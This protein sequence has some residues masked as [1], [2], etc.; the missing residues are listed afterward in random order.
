MET[1]TFAEGAEKIGLRGD[2]LD[3][4]IDAVAAD[5][6]RGDELKVDG[7]RCRRVPPSESGMEADIDVVF[8]LAAP[9]VPIFL[10]DVY[11]SGEEVMLS[12]QERLEMSKALSS[13]ADA[14]RTNARSKVVELRKRKE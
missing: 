2:E 6:A 13:V 5:P 11:L 10:L 4:V 7:V 8:F 12:R 1:P 14:Y 3:R 9:D